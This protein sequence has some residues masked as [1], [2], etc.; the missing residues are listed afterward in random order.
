MTMEFTYHSPLRYPGGKTRAVSSICKYIPKNERYLFSPFL[1]GGSVELECTRFMNVIGCDVF[2]PLITF[3]EM[4]IK[5]PGSLSKEV[6]K[7]YPLEKKM[8]YVLQNTLKFM[9]DSL[10][11]AAIFY[12]INR[13]SF[14]GTTFSGGMSP[15]HPRFTQSSIDRI[16]IFKSHNF[17]VKCGDFK[18]TLLKH[19][20]CFVYADPP[21]LIN[22]GL[23]GINGNTHTNFDHAGLS[24]L[25]HKRDRWVL[26]YNDCKE[27]RALYQGYKIYPINWT[28]G[29]SKN[30]KSNEIIITSN[31]VEI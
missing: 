5:K 13:S 12:V 16:S 30:K 20:D 11:I 7:Y 27:V 26:S 6:Q 15:G 18:N 24:K 17:S 10:E 28:Y 4:L 2:E 23:Y 31:E 21:Y 3:W 22:Q 1:G 14:S 9:T 29:M 25:L 19:E 8:F